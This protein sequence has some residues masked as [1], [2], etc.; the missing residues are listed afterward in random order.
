MSNTY[1][2]YSSIRFTFLSLNRELRNESQILPRIT[3]LLLAQAFFYPFLRRDNSIHF[4]LTQRMII[5]VLKLCTLIIAS[6]GYS[7]GMRS[8]FGTLYIPRTNVTWCNE[9]RKLCCS[10]LMLHGVNNKHATIRCSAI[11]TGDLRRRNIPQRRLK[12][13]REIIHGPS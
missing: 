7:S 5:F 12:V 11:N 2:N 1:K 8:N 4:F 13:L 6:I 3:L 10:H 9:T